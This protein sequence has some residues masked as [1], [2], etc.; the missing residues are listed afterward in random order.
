MPHSQNTGSVYR[1]TEQ[2]E[3]KRGDKTRLGWNFLTHLNGFKVEQT[4]NGL[5]AHLV[6]SRVHVFADFDSVQ[7]RRKSLSIRM[8]WVRPEDLQDR[9]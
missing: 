6:L 5:V 1:T 3:Y 2:C 9:A 4:V 7:T 8:H